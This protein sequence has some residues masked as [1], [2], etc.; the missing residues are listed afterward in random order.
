MRTA[1]FMVVLSVLSAPA[2]AQL[3][4]DAAKAGSDFEAK[5]RFLKPAGDGKSAQDGDFTVSPFA[6]L[7]KNGTGGAGGIDIGLPLNEK[8]SS[9]RIGVSGFGADKPEY[10][11]NGLT[12][13]ERFGG[14]PTVGYRQYLF[15]F[16]LGDKQ[17]KRGAFLEP[18]VGAGLAPFSGS[19][20]WATTEEDPNWHQEYGRW[21]VMTGYLSAGANVRFSDMFSAGLETRRYVDMQTPASRL[22]VSGF[23]L[24]F[25]PYK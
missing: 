13:K 3:E 10:Q 16:G 12:K 7:G 6:L 4:K 21:A 11:E 5:V 25:Y 22:Q 18:H 14:G 1:F 15:R 23:V 20:K 19:S 9:L 8:G 2:S 24:T 17:G